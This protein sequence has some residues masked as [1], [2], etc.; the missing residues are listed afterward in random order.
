MTENSIIDSVQ[1]IH[2]KE[3]FF[4]NTGLSCSQGLS[5]IADC[6]PLLNELKIN[7][8]SLYYEESDRLAEMLISFV[9]NFVTTIIKKYDFCKNYYWVDKGLDELRGQIGEAR[10]LIRK[11]GGLDMTDSR[12]HQV[13][14][15]ERS[16]EQTNNRL[17]KIE[18]KC[19]WLGLR[20]RI[21]YYKTP[22]ILVAVMLFALV[23]LTIATR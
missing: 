21:R 15:I 20:E 16:L 23:L 18:R 22:A 3:R 4:R 10:E 13:E 2:E 7:T 1:I 17:I 12:R 9:D 6:Q 14:W 19:K 8:D 11:V 5:L